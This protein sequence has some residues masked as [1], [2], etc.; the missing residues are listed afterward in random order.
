MTNS[1]LFFF[2]GGEFFSLTDKEKNGRAG[3][4]FFPYGDFFFTEYERRKKRT[5][6]WLFPAW[7]S[8]HLEVFLLVCHR[9]N[10]LTGFFANFFRLEKKMESSAE[11]FTILA[12]KKKSPKSQES[13]S[14]MWII[15]YRK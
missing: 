6:M 5:R 9:E 15:S 1:E 12:R 3:Y 13:E 7:K 2:P 10:A 11:R 8:V 4:F 14:M